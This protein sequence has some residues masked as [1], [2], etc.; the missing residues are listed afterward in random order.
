MNKP[1]LLTPLQTQSLHDAAEILRS[2]ANEMASYQGRV[3][4][5]TIDQRGL[6]DTHQALVPMRIGIAVS[7]EIR[8]LRG[9]ADSLTG[10][11]DD[12]SKEI[13]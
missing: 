8:R 7:T 2:E 1:V 12:G 5:V 13:S 6:P 9:L 10:L 4:K 3:F 11:A